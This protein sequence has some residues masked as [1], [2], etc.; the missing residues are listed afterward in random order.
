MKYVYLKLI[1]I[2]E[3]TDIQIDEIGNNIVQMY[4]LIGITNYGKCAR[5]RKHI[6]LYE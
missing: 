5:I 1:S 4:Q 2:A 6:K 3:P